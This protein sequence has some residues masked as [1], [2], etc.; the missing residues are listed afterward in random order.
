[1]SIHASLSELISMWWLLPLCVS[2]V[3][4]LVASMALRVGMMCLCGLWLLLAC[5]DGCC[6]SAGSTVV[7]AF[8]LFCPRPVCDRFLVIDAGC[9]DARAGA[10]LLLRIVVAGASDGMLLL[11]VSATEW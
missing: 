5:V 2:C 10:G 1:V 11:G 4:F 3:L 7:P 8:V 6:C 9:V